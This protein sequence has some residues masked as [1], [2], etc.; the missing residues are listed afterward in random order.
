[1]ASKPNLSKSIGFWDSVA[2]VIGGIVGTGIF[3]TPS[4]IGRYLSDPGWVL[5]A[6]VLGGFIAFLGT[7]CYSELSSSFPET[8]GNYVYLK[9]AYG[10]WAAG[11][12]RNSERPGLWR[13]TL[14]VAFHPS[15]VGAETDCV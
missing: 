14:P 10:P 4:E 5:F 13:D 11:R 6:W 3:R 2:L 1:M 12:A 9:Y 7:L 8:G 15:P